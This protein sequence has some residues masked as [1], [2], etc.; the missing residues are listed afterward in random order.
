MTPH[1]VEKRM[2]GHLTVIARDGEEVLIA[3][4]SNDSTSWAVTTYDPALVLVATE[5]ATILWWK[6]LQKNLEL[7]N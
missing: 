4:F 6:R 7:I 5:Y 2:G 3:N 1:V